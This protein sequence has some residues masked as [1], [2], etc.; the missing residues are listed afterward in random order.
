MRHKATAVHIAGVF[1]CGAPA[2]QHA[3]QQVAK[4]V[5]HNFTWDDRKY[6]FYDFSFPG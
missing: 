6:L 3:L 1:H 2:C 5:D 4:N